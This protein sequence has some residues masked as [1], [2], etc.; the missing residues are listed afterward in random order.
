MAEH[1]PVSA[2]RVCVF[3]GTFDPIH[4]AHLQIASEAVSEFGLNRVLLRS[5]G[6]PSAQTGIA[7]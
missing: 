1:T 4:N 3:G 7:R 6:K 5:G 2:Q